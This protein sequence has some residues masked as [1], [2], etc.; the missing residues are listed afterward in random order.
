MND[1]VLEQ[2]KEL[3]TFMSWTLVVVKDEN[4]KIVMIT[5]GEEEWL[6]EFYDI[7]HP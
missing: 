2:L 5:L 7:Q 6:D 3:A 4:E 1:L